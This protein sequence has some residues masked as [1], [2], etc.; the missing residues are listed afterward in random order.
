VIQYRIIV[1]DVGGVIYY[2]EP[3]ELAWVH[4][5]LVRA[6]AADASVTVTGL[7]RDMVSFYGAPDSR[8]A[9]TVF[10]LPLARDG[11]NAVRARWAALVQPIPGAVDAVL[12]LA[13]RYDVCVVANQPPECADTLQQLGLGR[14]LRLVA[15]DSVVGYAKP[16]PRLLDWALTKLGSPAARTLVVGNRWDHDIAPAQALGCPTTLVR[17]DDGWVAPEGSEPAIVAAYRSSK[18]TPRVAPLRVGGA[19]VVASLANLASALDG[20]AGTGRPT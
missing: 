16:D 20:V 13:A 15:L 4:E 18:N 10:S 6:R 12:R 7:I 9:K 3:F 17:Q 11:W 1:L 5:V 19:P 2:D 14:A 8:H